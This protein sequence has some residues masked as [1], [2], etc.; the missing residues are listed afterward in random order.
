MFKQYYT[1]N[2]N[3]FINNNH[4]IHNIIYFSEFY[5]SNVAKYFNILTYLFLE[6][7]DIT[8]Y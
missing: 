3:I 5:Q 1:N 6:C 7:E 8:T 2:T 4:Y